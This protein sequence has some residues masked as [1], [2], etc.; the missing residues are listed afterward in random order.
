MSLWKFETNLG[1]KSL[2]CSSLFRARFAS[3]HKTFVFDIGPA[4]YKCYPN[5]LCL[6]G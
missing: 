1:M 4:L 3:K 2:I 5:V 6:L